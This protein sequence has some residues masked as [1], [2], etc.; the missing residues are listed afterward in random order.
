[1][2]FALGANMLPEMC[3]S[4]AKVPVM[5][6]I[7]AWLALISRL[8]CDNHTFASAILAY[9]ARLCSAF[10]VYDPF[11]APFRACD[12]RRLLPGWSQ[13]LSKIIA[14]GIT[15]E[16]WNRR[17]VWKWPLS[18]VVLNKVACKQDSFG[19]DQLFVKTVFNSN[20]S[21]CQKL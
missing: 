10:R 14:R 17:K 13:E 7:F 16:A 20:F 1:M 21:K 2:I 6:D 15:Y 8:T 3:L 12:N 11:G 18:M 19:D 4:S 5:Q 9:K